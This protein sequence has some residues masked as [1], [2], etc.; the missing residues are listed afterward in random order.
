MKYEKVTESQLNELF[1]VL[2]LIQDR[3]V[4]DASLEFR[5]EQAVWSL[6]LVPLAELHQ[7]YET[8]ARDLAAE[9]QRSIHWE[10]SGLD[11]LVSG[12]VRESMSKALIHAIRNSLDHGVEAP[13]D[14]K[15]L[16]KN[17]RARLGLDARLGAAALQLT[18][19]DDGRGPEG[20]VIR[21]RAQEMGWPSSA[22]TEPSLEILFEPGFSTVDADASTD[23]SGRGMGLDAVREGFRRVGGE[24]RAR[25]QEGRGFALEMEVPLDALGV[26]VR[27]VACLD[28]V[29][30]VPVGSVSEASGFSAQEKAP[31]MIQVYGQ[32]VSAASLGFPEFK[33]FRKLDPAWGRIGP[34][35]LQSWMQTM[36]GKVL[37]TAVRGEGSDAF[38]GSGS[39]TGRREIIPLMDAQTWRSLNQLSTP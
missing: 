36:E 21:S 4:L 37:A 22:G 18:F 29:F 9:L 38:S 20:G 1:E 30:F 34:S 2:D 31:L 33:Y 10:S 25:G 24:V 26:E 13:E 7:Q 19:S 6:R 39:K 17:P 32:E 35:W 23:L 16:G 15:N 14:R 11:I 27:K 8:Y 12:W 5:L 28:R 3:Q